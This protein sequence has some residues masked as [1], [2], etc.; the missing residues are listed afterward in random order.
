MSKCIQTL[1][2]PLVAKPSHHMY[3]SPRTLRQS[4]KPYI[5]H[6]RSFPFLFHYY[7][8][9]ITVIR[10]ITVIIITVILLLLLNCVARG[11][12][13]CPGLGLQLMQGAF[14]PGFRVP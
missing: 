10:K 9:T 3:L 11:S 12:R 5:A 1:L 2:G 13:A 14:I 7:D 8:T 6:H 4:P